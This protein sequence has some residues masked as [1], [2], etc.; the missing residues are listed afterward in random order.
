MDVS[1]FLPDKHALSYRLF[2]SE[3]KTL[4]VRIWKMADGSERVEVTTR[5]TVDGVW[6][7]PIQLYETPT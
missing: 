5:A 7:P 1:D 2:L 4:L 6:A 3:D